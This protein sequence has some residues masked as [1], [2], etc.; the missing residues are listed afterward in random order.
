M[1]RAHLEAEL[2][3][4]RRQAQREL[5]RTLGVPS[6]WA[7]RRADQLLDRIDQL[8]FVANELAREQEAA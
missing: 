2:V 3:A 4:H 7:H 8:D 5:W 6:P 1:S